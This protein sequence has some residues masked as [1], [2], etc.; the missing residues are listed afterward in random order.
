MSNENE[1]KIQE[2]R[3][4]RDEAEARRE[5]RSQA[6]AL[7]FEANAAIAAEKLDELE[8]Q[9]GV[10]GVGLVS[11][12]LPDGRI[13]VAKRPAAATYRKFVD[14]K[15]GSMSEQ[16]GSFV[17]PCIV[18]PDPGTYAALL[19]DFP[20]LVAQLTVELCKLAGQRNVEK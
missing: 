9:Y 6:A 17:K 18:F 16:A 13:V 19:E 20:A 15:Q 14:A 2:L 7:A 8:G 11:V 3:R 12:S 1:S 4:R 10:V 5:L